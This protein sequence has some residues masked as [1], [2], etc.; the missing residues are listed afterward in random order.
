MSKCD[1]LVD[2]HGGDIDE[3]IKGF[4]VA[5]EGKD[6]KVNA[7]ALVLASC[8][9]CDLTHIFPA[10][11]GM[12]LSAQGIYGIP[13]IMPE[14]GTPYPVREEAVRFHFEGVMNVL[15]YMHI[16]GGEP[17]RRAPRVSRKRLRVLASQI[18]AWH[19]SIELDKEVKK[20]AELGRV[21]DLFGDTVQIAKAPE[22][23]V[24]G[25]MRCFYSVNRGETLAVVSAFD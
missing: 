4:V 5:A 2:C 25:M 6:A 21:T 23:G 7:E 17:K 24:V 15:R 14:A 18:G 20:G 10:S 22:G 11:G 12:S 8:F 19:P 3:D 9:P 13:C 1:A 16:L